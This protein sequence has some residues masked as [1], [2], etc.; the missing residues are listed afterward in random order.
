MLSSVTGLS[1]GL[2]ID[3]HCTTK[4]CASSSLNRGTPCR[5]LLSLILKRCPRG[6]QGRVARRLARGV[7]PVK[8]PLPAGEPL[9]LPLVAADWLNNSLLRHPLSE[10]FLSPWSRRR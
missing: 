10:R 7:Y 8:K 4:A 2:S 5:G 6:D 1:A 9:E 3:C